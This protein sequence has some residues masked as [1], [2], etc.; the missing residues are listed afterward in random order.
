V[1][2]GKFDGIII[3]GGFGQRGTNG[4]LNVIKQARILGIPFLGI[5]LGFQLA[6]IEFSKNVCKL[7][8]PNSQEFCESTS[9]NVI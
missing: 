3:P 2:L 6:I 7:D 8:N 4:M 5:C 1:G 9:D